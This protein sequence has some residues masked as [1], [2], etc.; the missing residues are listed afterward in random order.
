VTEAFGFKILNRDGAARRGELTTAHGV[1]Q[2]PAFMPVGTRAAVKAVTKRDLLDLGAEII[3][4]NTYHLYL[5]PGDGLIARCGGL[6]RFMSWDRPILTDSGGY[7]VFSLSDIRKIREEGAEFRSHLDGSLHLL[8][9]EKAV[10]IQQQ[11]G[12]DIAMVL[13][14][15]VASD[16][17]ASD[18]GAKPISGGDGVRKA[19]ERSVRWARRGRERQLRLRE[20]PGSVADVVV[21]NPGQA[22]FGIVQGGTSPALRTESVQQTV[23]IGFEAYAIGGLS[24][25]EP[26]E[27]MYE[28]VSHTA[29]LLPEAR[30]RYLMGTGMPDDLIE[31]VARG[32]DMFDCVLPTRNGRN[33]QLLTRHGVLVIKNARYA[34][35]L[36]PPD[37]EC[38]CYTCRNFS[39]AYLRHLFVAGE[40]AAATLNSLHN[41]YFYLDTMRRIREAI[42]FGSFEKL[43]QEF[44]QTFSRRAQN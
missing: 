3:L 25:G 20:D 33:G 8:T 7:Q 12:S 11:L 39:R 43:R 32:I 30:P 26:V 9:P 16:R 23:E 21:S 44:H 10:D 31:C 5:R 17:P 37:P 22:Q 42:V 15:C 18:A 28:V 19:M 27:V 24:V 35:D 14:E 40:M 29:P 6:H 38:G 1:V 34:Q 41:L 13:D 4:G 36:L 2:T